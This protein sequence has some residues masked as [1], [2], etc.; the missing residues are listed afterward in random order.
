MYSFMVSA[1]IIEQFRDQTS[2]FFFVHNYIPFFSYHRLRIDQLWPLFTERY[3]P[4]LVSASNSSPLSIKSRNSNNCRPQCGSQVRPPFFEHSRRCES[5]DEMRIIISP[6]SIILGMVMMW[7]MV[8]VKKNQRVAR[9]SE[10]MVTH[11]GFF[12]SVAISSGVS[13]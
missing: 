8:K 9:Y 10:R 1:G 3:K 4:L 5:L 6:R 13:P 2:Q 7:V 12:H 11:S